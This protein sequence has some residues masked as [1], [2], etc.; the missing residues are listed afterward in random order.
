M[1]PL[2][3]SP[4]SSASAAR[5]SCRIVREVEAVIGVDEDEGG[6]RGTGMRAPEDLRVEHRVAAVAAAER[7]WS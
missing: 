1:V 4:R 7:S 6:R 5:S 3:L 2:G